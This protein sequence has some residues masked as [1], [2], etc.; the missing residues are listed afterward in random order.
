MKEFSSVKDML[1]KL[2]LK[3]FNDNFDDLKDKDGNIKITTNWIINEGEE[4]IFA[5]E[6]LDI[7]F[8]NIYVVVNTSFFKPWSLMKKH[9]NAYHE[10]SKNSKWESIDTI[11]NRGQK[12]STNSITF[13][14]LN[15][16]FKSRKKSKKLDLGK[17]IDHLSF[18]P[19]KKK[20]IIALS[21]EE[22]EKEKL[23]EIEEAKNS[24]LNISKNVNIE[25]FKILD[26]GGGYIGFCA[27]F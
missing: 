16:C 15:S 27:S 8:K 17:I 18:P 26:E 4:L 11:V 12:L 5:H 10:I 14:S 6:K 20:V 25:D 7:P 1:E 13:I 3:I 2:L 21:S 24:V 23:K 9:S 22:I 19:T